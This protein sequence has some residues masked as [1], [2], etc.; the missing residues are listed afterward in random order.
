MVFGC[1]TKENKIII[2]ESLLL[3]SMEKSL[4][5]FDIVSNSSDPPAFKSLP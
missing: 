1:K 4:K 5:K 3:V 2:K